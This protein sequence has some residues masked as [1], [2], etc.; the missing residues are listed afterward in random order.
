MSVIVPLEL[1]G[2]T[3]VFATPAGPFVAVKNVNL[4]VQRSEFVCILGHSGCGKSTVL[5][6]IAGLQQASYGGVVING[7]QTVEPGDDRA[8]VFQTPSL[9]PWLTARENVMLAVKQKFRAARTQ[10]RKAHVDHYLQLTG[11]GDAA[12]QLP[13]ELSLGTQQCVSLARALALQPELLLLDEPFSMLDS[14]TRLDLQDTLLGAWEENRTIVV[15]VTHDVDE[16]LFLADRIVLMTDG[17]EARVGDLLTLPFPR[18]RERHEVLGHPQYYEYRQHVIDFLENHAKQSAM[19]SSGP[20]RR[21]GNLADRLYQS[22]QF[23]RQDEHVRR[24]AHAVDA[25]GGVVD[26]SREN[27][28]L[29]EQRVSEVGRLHAR[30][31]DVGDTARP[32]RVRRRVEHDVLHLPHFVRPVVLQVA[33]PRFLSLRADH[34]VKV[35]RVAD[36]EVR[37]HRMCAGVIQLQDVSVL[38]RQRVAIDRSQRA[39][40]VLAHVR[41]PVPSGQPSHLWSDAP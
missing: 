38:E 25:R 37:R 32:R 19:V 23:F 13:A 6:I 1:T 3:K 17:P 8:V 28:V 18:P 4:R 41:M 5:S 26:T 27:L 10:A 34:V 30:D 16:A 15:M 11:V 2:L 39:D 22:I 9:L 20:L 35:D 12:D 21:A 31:A 7:R 29:V 33:Q 40:L 24:H 14:L 36:R